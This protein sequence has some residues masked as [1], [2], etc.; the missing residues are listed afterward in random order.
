MKSSMMI[1]ALVCAMAGTASAQDDFESG[2]ETTEETTTETTEVSAEAS[3]SAAV[4]TTEGAAGG[5]GYQ[6]GIQASFNSAADEGAVH[7]LYGLGG[8]YLDLGL[9][10][11]VESSTNT[12]WNLD[13]ELGY[14]MMRPLAG[15]VQPYLKPLVIF[16]IASETDAAGESDTSIAFGAGAAFGVDYELFPQFTLGTEVGAALVYQ[17]TDPDAT[18]TV[19]LVTASLKATF[20]W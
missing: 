8:N 5:A 10:L 2:N 6:Y 13:L 19:D 11:A 20:W 3:G 9:G 15:R 18:I 17:D 12:E 7:L 16:S 4:T 14:R 1:A